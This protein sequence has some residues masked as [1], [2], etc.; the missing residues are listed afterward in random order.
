MTHIISLLYFL[1]TFISE[2]IL[3]LLILNWNKNF[4]NISF[5]SSFRDCFQS[6]WMMCFSGLSLQTW[7]VFHNWVISGKSS[8]ISLCLWHLHSNMQSDGPLQQSVEAI[9]YLIWIL[10]HIPRSEPSY[11]QQRNGI[12]YERVAYISSDILNTSFV[13]NDSKKMLPSFHSYIQTL[14]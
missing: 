9:C 2:S 4:K 6:K 14:Y 7:Q 3:L 11:Q 1:F 5:N 10:S 13:W 8:T 12:R